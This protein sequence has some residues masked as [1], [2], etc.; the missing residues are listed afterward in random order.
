M[1]KILLFTLALAVILSV[2]AC[3]GKEDAP[4]SESAIPPDES[5]LYI[6]TFE[7]RKID[8]EEY[9]L[10]RMLFDDHDCAVLIKLLVIEKLA[11]EYDVTI[12]QDKW[13]DI[14]DFIAYIKEQI[15][16]NG[17][18]I[19]TLTDERMAGLV[20]AYYYYVEELS[21]YL[22]D[23]ESGDVDLEI[24]LTIE[25]INE[26]TAATDYEINKRAYYNLLAAQD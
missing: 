26:L 7:G 4:V 15:E 14:Y 2:A 11:A 25:K 22:A 21:P 3:G 20:A 16:S 13:D 8:I 18:A 19:P 12:G 23:Y 1:K 9:K 5:L 10:T 17:D 24:Q 6:M